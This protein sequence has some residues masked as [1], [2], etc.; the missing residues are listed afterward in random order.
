MKHLLFIIIILSFCGCTRLMSDKPE[1]LIPQEKMIPILVDLHI[2]DALAEQKNGTQN[3]NLPLTNA[4]YTRIYHNYGISAD[5]YKSSY[6]YYE[7]HPDQMD[8]MYT[9]VITELSKKEIL[10]KK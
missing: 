2:A 8:T 7:S 5:Q 3:L 1:G 6:K 9:K 4:L 10:L